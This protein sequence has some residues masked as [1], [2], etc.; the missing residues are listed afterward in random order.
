MS[1]TKKTKATTPRG[2]AIANALE[3][4]ATARS[5]VASIDLRTCT[6]PLRGAI[7]DAQTNLRSGVDHLEVALREHLK[8]EAG[9]Q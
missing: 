2:T 7:K 4:L 5:E 9:K 3:A 8:A 1:T 6:L